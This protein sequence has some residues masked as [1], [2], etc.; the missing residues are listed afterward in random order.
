M[1]AIWSM[2]LLRSISRE[3]TWKG[4][5]SGPAGRS[6]HQLERHTHA[7]KWPCGGATRDP[8]MGPLDRLVPQSSNCTP[9]IFLLAMFF[10]LRLHP[11]GTGRV[12]IKKKQESEFGLK[13]SFKEFHSSGINSRCSKDGLSFII[14]GVTTTLNM[15]IVYG[16]HE[17][18]NIA[19]N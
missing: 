14:F 10:N 18:K 17:L 13:V 16:T 8:A 4:D 15:N 6:S 3:K 7:R 2:S 19:W 1:C 9:F 12:G 5:C 11:F